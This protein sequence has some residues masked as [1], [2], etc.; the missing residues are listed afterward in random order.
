[1]PLVVNKDPD[2]FRSGFAFWNSQ[3]DVMSLATPSDRKVIFAATLF[4]CVRSSFPLLDFFV[5]GDPD[6]RLP[7]TAN[8]A[9]EYI[10]GEGILPSQ[11]GGHCRFKWQKLVSGSRHCRPTRPYSRRG[12]GVVSLGRAGTSGRAEPVTG[13]CIWN[14]ILVLNEAAAPSRPSA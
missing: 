10:E 1:M 5:T 12:S 6:N 9:F 2:T 11:Q 13:V 7:N 8:V 3:T 14:R 4:I